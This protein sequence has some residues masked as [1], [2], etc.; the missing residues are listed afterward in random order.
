[1]AL[2]RVLGL[3]TYQTNGGQSAAAPA[4]DW[5]MAA[6][7]SEGSSTLRPTASAL[8][9]TPANVAAD[10]SSIFASAA[11]MAEGPPALPRE[12]ACACDPRNTLER[13]IRRHT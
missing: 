7:R 12:T 13:S 8:A 3:G 9:A 2:V 5:R 1:M 10:A 11:L 6:S 4:C